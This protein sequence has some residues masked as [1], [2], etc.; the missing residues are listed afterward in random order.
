MK[1]AV[2]CLAG[3]AVLVALAGCGAGDLAGADAE[4]P[5]DSRPVSDAEDP[6]SREDPGEPDLAGIC[7]DEP[8][9]LEAWERCY[10]LRRCQRLVNCPPLARY[11][12]VAECLELA[13]A[14]EGGRLSVAVRER[15]GAIERGS[16]RIDVDAFAR[17]LVE[18][19]PEACNTAP[20][21]VACATR[22]LGTVADGGECLTDI[23]CESPGAI[24]ER[25]CVEACCP[26]RCQ[27][28]IREDEHCVDDD[29]CAPGL[30]CKLDGNRCQ[31]GGVDTACASASDCD[32]G[33]WC[34]W[35]EGVCKADLAPGEE[36]RYRSQ[37]GGET[38]C[39]GASPVGAPGR[40]LR[41]SRPGDVC[42]SQCYGNL[43]CVFEDPASP[44]GACRPLP[45][46]G[47]TCAPLAPCGSVT[48]VC[49]E[50]RCVPRADE[51]TGCEDTPCLPGLFCSA[52]LD[53]VDPV[54]VP[55]LGADERCTRATHCESYLCS[56]DPERPGQCL[57]WRET[58]D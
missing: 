31:S 15:R 37:C 38:T 40:C 33:G 57:P 20:R 27:P 58:C 12:D 6:D 26:G 1:V 49:K 22:F 17:C 39:V 3:V 25:D 34:D 16:A 14:V 32:P 8:V 52:E 29:A 56:G 53:P 41:V 28:K 7:G 23:E 13:D 46:L 2:P 24:C 11:R 18:A 9:T 4:L 10:H 55:R 45:Q 47:E 54:C 35:G 36:C 51:G 21:H 50:G 19:G 5:R 43:R 44:L 42:D 48:L 30:L